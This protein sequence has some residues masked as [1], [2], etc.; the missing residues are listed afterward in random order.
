MKTVA[1]SALIA[2]AVG[3]ASIQAQSL[4]AP[5]AQ[6]PLAGQS[7]VSDAELDTFASIYVDLL[8]TIEK[9]E[10]QMET[11]QSEQQAQEVRV[12]MQEES[13]AKVARRGWTPEKFNDVT[14]A[15]N[16]DPRLSERAAQLID[17]KT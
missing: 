15:I 9:F 3:N 12:K 8:E 10:P 6:A 14:N 1:L 16:S 7:A 11:A 2:L 17:D 4:E 5:E 13:L